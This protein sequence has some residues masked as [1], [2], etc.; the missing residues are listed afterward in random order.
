MNLVPH[1]RRRSFHGFIRPGHSALCPGRAL[2]AKAG[3]SLP[4]EEA[5]GSGRD[6]RFHAEDHPAT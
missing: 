5:E 2:R 4:A 6:G 1:F 3:R